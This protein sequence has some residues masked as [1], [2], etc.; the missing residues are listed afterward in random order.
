MCN[1]RA[2][3][4]AVGKTAIQPREVCVFFSDPTRK[5]NS[6]TIRFVKETGGLFLWQ[7]LFSVICY[8]LLVSGTSNHK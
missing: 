4:P 3:G 8:W 6:V 2:N 7:S 1:T 5:E